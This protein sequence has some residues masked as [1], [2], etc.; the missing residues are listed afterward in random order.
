MTTGPQ[1]DF[2]A[3]FESAPGCYLVLDPDLVIVAVSDAYLRAT[4]T[5]RAELA[6]R[7]VFEAFPDNPEDP[8]TEGARNLQ[9]SLARVLR[10]K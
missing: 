4:M 3:L 8:A 7:P 1:P 9:A 10:E 5:R 2:R 6:G